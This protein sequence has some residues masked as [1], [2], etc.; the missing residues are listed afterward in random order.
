MKT[1]Y[2]FWPSFFRWVAILPTSVIVTSLMYYLYNFLF[3]I[4]VERAE[5]TEPGSWLHLVLVGILS[6]ALAGST[7]VL[8]GSSVAPSHK[9]VVALVMAGLVLVTSGASLL[10]ANI[11]TKEYFSNIGIICGNIGAIISSVSIYR[12]EMSVDKD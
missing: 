10:I 1:E 8:V 4:L 2:K 9:K 11:L 5:I 6:N 12:G 3:S 7:F